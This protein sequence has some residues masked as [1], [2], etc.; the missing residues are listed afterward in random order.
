MLRGNS[1]L[2]LDFNFLARHRLHDSATKLERM[3]RPEHRCERAPAP[4]AIRLFACEGA[5]SFA[6]GKGHRGIMGAGPGDGA[7]RRG[8]ITIDAGSLERLADPPLS[9]AA[10][11]KRR[12]ARLGKDT[13]V[14][15]AKGSEPI[16]QRLDR[17]GRLTI[18]AAL[19]DLARQIG[20]E[21]RSRGCITADIMEREPFESSR[22][23]RS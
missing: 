20:T 22:I 8:I 10:P 18:P 13:V 12:R 15:I 1:L 7:C 11:P 14:D 17:G 5:D 9:V 19:G 21:F 6:P 23:E 3:A 4:V 16:H 2:T